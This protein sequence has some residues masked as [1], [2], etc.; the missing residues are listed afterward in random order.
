MMSPFLRAEWLEMLLHKSSLNISLLTP[1]SNF[2]FVVSEQ[3]LHFM[4]RIFQ[5]ETQIYLLNQNL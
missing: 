2:Q 5:K 3:K 1:G 4:L